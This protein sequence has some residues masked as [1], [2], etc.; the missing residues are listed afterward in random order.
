MC[1]LIVESIAPKHN[2]TKS[3]G[4]RKELR[5]VRTLSEDLCSED[6]TELYA[7]LDACRRHALAKSS[8]LSVG[9]PG[10]LSRVASQDP[11]FQATHSAKSDGDGGPRAQFTPELLIVARPRLSEASRQKSVTFQDSEKLA[12][13]QLLKANLTETDQQLWRAASAGDATGILEALDCNSSGRGS[14]QQARLC[15]RFLH[16][17]TALHAAASSGQPAAVRTLLD[18]GAA[19]DARSD[20]GCTALHEASEHGYAAL[21]SLLLD[22]RAEPLLETDEQNLA[23]HLAASNG[24]S[25]TVLTLLESDC[26]Q[27][28]ARNRMGQRP[29]DM[30]TDRETLAV[31]LRFPAMPQADTYVGRSRHAG[32]TRR[33]SRVDYV[34]RLLHAPT[35]F[36]A[37]V[38]DE[39]SS[40]SIPTAPERRP[41][42][43]ERF[44]VAGQSIRHG[45][46]VHVRE[47]D[48][49]T[50]RVGPGSFSYVDRIG[51]GAFGEV[52]LVK[53]KTTGEAYAMK[54]L[55]RTGM[56]QLQLR[57]AT[58]ERNVL[59]YLHHPYIVQL[60]Y[61]FQTDTRLVLVMQ[62]CSGG[63]LQGLIDREGCLQTPVARL[64]TAEVLLA[65]EHIHAR[66]I[67]Y[68]DLKPENV[69]IDEYGHALLTDFGLAKENVGAERTKS[70]VGSPAFMAPELLRPGSAHDRMVDVYGLGVLLHCMAVGMPP[71]Y[72]D[73]RET[74]ME[75]I[76]SAP[77][78]LPDSL[79]ADSQAIIRDLLH[80]EPSRRLGAQQTGDVRGHAFFKAL[81]WEALL[82]RELPV[83]KPPSKPGPQDAHQEDR[84]F[85]TS[86]IQYDKDAGEDERARA[87]S[88]WNFTA[89]GARG[90]A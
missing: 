3:A 22:C 52:F 79:D 33:N 25:A 19:V 16:G 54:V 86:D 72:S 56:R 7:D 41:L 73:R 59:S 11:R 90:G 82:L 32:V 26:A 40:Y 10:L 17:R 53:H 76:S 58:T 30:A 34:R 18:M 24:H 70:F 46:F 77:L 15:S 20:A 13:P 63:D 9:A 4:L 65:L 83:P 12:V 43:A 31:F 49:A 57:Y 14:Q 60:F 89:A 50:A 21:V 85:S 68:R 29:G 42:A 38:D 45:H 44:H 2:S 48:P 80:R 47:G 6:F 78:L 55:R 37:N 61:A 8:A 51:G 84:P 67:V 28:G 75:N 1:E 88:G 71:Y 64:Y 39:S 62:Y 81:H 5:R 36:Q 35:Q 74:L 27:L 69:L 23:I 87:V 66:D